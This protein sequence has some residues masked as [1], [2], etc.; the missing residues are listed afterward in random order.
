MG[1]MDCNG[2]GC[3]SRFEFTDGLNSEE[4][5]SV[6]L[7]MKINLNLSRM[8]YC[9]ITMKVTLAWILEESTSS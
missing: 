7:R 3:F 9:N 2:I 8:L 5:Y 1:T 6:N 4:K